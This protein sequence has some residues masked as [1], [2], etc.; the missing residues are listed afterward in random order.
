MKKCTYHH[1]AYTKGYISRK[2]K[3]TAEEILKAGGGCPYKGRY[4]EG[5]T[6]ETPC[7]NT[8]Q[9]HHITYFIFD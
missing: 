8:T 1:T 6:V 2:D 5:Y 9:Y 3:R 4:G 7:Y